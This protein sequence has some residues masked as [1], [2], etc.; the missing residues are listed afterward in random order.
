MLL[1]GVDLNLLVETIDERGQAWLLVPIGGAPGGDGGGRG[2]REGVPGG[3]EGNVTAA[4]DED[5]DEGQRA[6][7][8]AGVPTDGPPGEPSR[9]R[10]VSDR[11]G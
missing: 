6:E 5:T 7:G 10:D 9:Q 3:G 1:I 11:R 2:G 8:A 4:G